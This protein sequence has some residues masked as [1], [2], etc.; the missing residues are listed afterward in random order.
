MLL[1]SCSSV[2]P[3][4]DHPIVHDYGNGC[5]VTV[6]QT[7][8]DALEKDDIVEMCVID[9]TSAW[10]LNHTAETAI[11]KHAKKACKCGA[12][13]VYVQGLE[14]GARIALFLPFLGDAVDADSA[15][16]RE[17]IGYA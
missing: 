3:I 13:K 7:E 9:G 14:R 4:S 16:N 8:A 10:S 15:T 17:R 6:Y 11:K 2:T 12:D 5:R 1:A